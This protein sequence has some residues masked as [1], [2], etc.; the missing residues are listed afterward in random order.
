MKDQPAMNPLLESCA[1]QL[2]MVD[3]EDSAEIAE[4]YQLF[5]RFADSLQDAEP[6]LKNATNAALAILGNIVMG[7]SKDYDVDFEI[8]TKTICALQAIASGKNAIPELFPKELKLDTT[9]HDNKIDNSTNQLQ[10][11]SVVDYELFQAYINQQSLV[12]AEWE[13]LCLKYESEDN[14]KETIAAIKR[15]VHTMKGE[16]GVLGLEI[17]ASFCHDLEDYMEQAQII[18]ADQLF[19]ALDWC[20]E[21]IVYFSKKENAPPYTNL[22]KQQKNEIDTKTTTELKSGQTK[23]S[24]GYIVDDTEL[25]RDFITEAHEHF[26]IADQ[27]LLLLEEEPNNLEAVAAVFRSFHT[28]KGVAG[29]LGLTPIC[30]LAHVAE[31]L[32]DEVRQGKRIFAGTTIEASFQAVDMLKI[33]VGDLNNCL[34]LDAEFH[35]NNKLSNIIAEIKTVL[36]NTKQEPITIITQKNIPHKIDDNTKLEELGELE[37]LAL[38]SD[39]KIAE[40]IKNIGKKKSNDN[41]KTT[42]IKQ[43]MKVEVEKIDL[44]LDTIGELVI[45]NSIVEQDP[46]ILQANSQRLQKNLG[47][48]TKITRVLQDMGMDMR[49]VPIEATFRKMARLVRDLAKKAGKNIKFQMIGKETELDKGL[50]EKLSDPLVHMIRN[51]VDHGIE[52]TAEERIKNGKEKCGHITLKAYH[53]GGSIHIEIVDDGRGLNRDAIIVKALERGVIETA[54]NMSNQEIFALIFEPGFSTAAKVTEISGRGVGMDVVKRNIEALRGSIIINS[55]QNK[56]TTFTIVLPLTMAIIDGMQVKTNNEIFIIPTLAII[57][58]LRPS[59]E[60][61]STVVGEGGLLIS[62]REELVPL[63]RLSDI[64]EMGIEA[65][66]AWEAIVIVLEEAGQLIAIQVD[67]ILGQHQTV[68]KSLGEA[69]GRV[70]GISGASIMA[71]GTPGLIIDVAGLHKLAKGGDA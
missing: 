43:T 16:A 23:E 48:L 29:F 32:L 3:V 19:D 62:F 7:E 37:E 70:E 30:D 58:S 60:M 8:I 38:P 26:E 42:G 11:A 33:M 53:K 14:K 24:I 71:D 59:K 9:D 22:F 63:F 55:K 65:K 13:R 4:Y 57:E 39:E 31:T 6:L 21:A 36:K 27:N 5:S 35:A 15:I 56:G 41:S 44:L 34:S 50:V 2:V 1:E 52:P 28:I 51:S 47:H 40:Q 25:A 20:K 64:F 66:P 61:I 12:F 18:D 49:M 17:M 54:E 69:V 45:A 68:I 10:L 46:I 67:D